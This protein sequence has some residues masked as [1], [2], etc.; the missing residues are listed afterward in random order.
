MTTFILSSELHG[1]ADTKLV[2]VCHSPGKA[3]WIRMHRILLLTG[4]SMEVIQVSVLWNAPLHSA[5]YCGGAP[6]KQLNIVSFL[7]ASRVVNH[8]SFTAVLPSLWRGYAKCGYVW[9]TPIHC[10]FTQILL[11]KLWRDSPRALNKKKIRISVQLKYWFAIRDGDSATSLIVD[12]VLVCPVSPAAPGW[13]EQAGCC[14]PLCDAQWDGSVWSACWLP[15]YCACPLPLS[16]LRI[17]Y[18]KGL[19]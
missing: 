16:P 19:D 1:F 7:S 15:L 13:C 8:F 10:I 9:P 17:Q 6:V 2:E 11:R 12:F 3:G 5:H 4:T 14:C 18:A